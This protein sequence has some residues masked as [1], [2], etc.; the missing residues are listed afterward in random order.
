M[1]ISALNQNSISFSDLK[2]KFTQVT[3]RSADIAISL[4]AIVAFTPLLAYTAYKIKQEDKGPILFKQQ[5]SG[6]NNIPFEIYKF[7]SMKVKKQQLPSERV[8]DLYAYFGQ[9]VP[10]D[11]IFKTLE[12]NN[13]NVTQVGRWI[14]KYSVDELPQLFNVLKGE[15][16]IVGP[17]PEIVAITK[18]YDAE[19]LKRL[20]VKPGITGWAQVNGRSE[21]NHGL[22]IKY[23][24]Y[25]VNNESVWLYFKIIGMTLIQVLQGKGS[26]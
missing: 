8:E 22:K 18:Y 3:K 4:T 13:P 23:D 20:K 11:F 2:S 9:R 24:I 19:Q 16:S 15:M 1:K 17:R 25:Y 26:V 5:R 12:S 7:R 21:I 14:R 6:L 10:D